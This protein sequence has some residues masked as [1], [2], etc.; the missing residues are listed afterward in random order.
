MPIAEVNGQRIAY[1]DTGGSGPAVM[2]AHGLLMDRSMFDAQVA[3]LRDEFRC[4]AWDARGFGETGPVPDPFSFWDSADDQLALA[5]HLGV[6]TAFLVGMSQGGFVN[7]RTALR[8]PAFVRGLVLLDTQ[9]GTEDPDLV[10]QYAAMS[11][12]WREHGLGDDLAEMVAAIILSPGDPANA[13]WIAKWKALPREHMEVPLQAL[14]DRDDLHDRLGEI[15]APAIVIHGEVDA[16]IPL[17]KAQRLAD[18]LPGCERLLVVPG[19]HAANVAYP[20]PVN[21]ALLDFVR[22]HSGIRPGVATT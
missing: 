17:E 11:E 22:R 20:E 15:T 8:R 6:E 10:P 13:D 12:V 7:L 5:D 9:A 18:G 4:V 16:A 19:G 14:F 1:D 21:R 2:F 3:A